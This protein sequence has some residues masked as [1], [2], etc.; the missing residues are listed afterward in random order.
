MNADGWACER[1]VHAAARLR[2]RPAAARA[3]ALQP[4]DLHAAEPV[5]RRSG[6]SLQY[7]ICYTNVLTMLDLGGIAAARRGPRA[8]RHAGHRRRARRAEPRAARPVTSTCSS[9]ATASR[10]CRSSATCG[11]SMQ[12][13]PGL[14]RDE[15][16]ARIAGSGGLGL[17]PPVLRADLPRRRHD[18]SRSRRT[19]RRRPRGDQALRDPTTSTASRCRP[20]PIVPFVETAHDRIAIEIMRGCPWQCRFCQST[21][22]KRPLRYRTVETIVN[23]A[24]E[25]YQATPATTRSACSRSRRATTRISR[26]W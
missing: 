8:G 20:R 17:R 16:L 14:S 23:A 19:P 11:T 18:R 13:D 7:E 6:F 24:L 5:R 9:S 1:V 10:A 15:K 22:I 3:A 2:G 26:S 4:G 25:S 21:V 12:G